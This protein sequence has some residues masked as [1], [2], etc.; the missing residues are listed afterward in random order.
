MAGLRRQHGGVS[1]PAAPPEGNWDEV[2]ARFKR[3]AQSAARM[4]HPNIVAIYEIGNH[5]ELNFF[6]MRLVR[7][8]GC[9]V[10]S[11]NSVSTP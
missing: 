1:A 3:E 5:E 11:R 2:I 4:Q 6:S 9:R 8:P 10:A 7:G